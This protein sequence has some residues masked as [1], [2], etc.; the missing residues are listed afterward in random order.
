MEKDKFYFSYFKRERLLNPFV[1]VCPK[2]MR[3]HSAEELQNNHFCRH[4]GKFLTYRDKRGLTT[5][6]GIKEKILELNTNGNLENNKRRIAEFVVKWYENYI[7]E[8]QELEEL[9]LEEINANH[10]DGKLEIIFLAR[11]FS[12]YRLK[13]EKALEIWRQIKLWFLR[14]SYCY[15]EIFDKENLI[16]LK[17]LERK[18][19]ELGFPGDPEDLINQIGLA[20][21]RLKSADGEIKFERK[22]TWKETLESLA[23]SLRGTGIRQKAFWIFRVLKQI[24]EWKD[25]PGEFCCVSDRHVKAFL[26]KQGFISHLDKDLFL[27]SKVIWK[28]FNEP[29]KVKYYDLPVFRF[30]RIHKCAKCYVQKCGLVDLTKCTRSRD[31]RK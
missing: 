25:V 24:G 21:N 16:G 11:L 6:S 27:N 20:I 10:S 12:Q 17:K 30:A 23:D 18:L 9:F 4:C 1:Y 29:F 8:N 15:R 7:K 22:N 14:E 28:Y 5:Y 19:I 3:E 26:K 31:L 2:C 13:E